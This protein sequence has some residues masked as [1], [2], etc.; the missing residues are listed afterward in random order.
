[1]QLFSRQSFQN[2]LWT[3]PPSYAQL[4]FEYILDYENDTG[5]GLEIVENRGTII[6]LEMPKNAIYSEF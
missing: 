4:N 3:E 1:M 6:P 5:L 2:D